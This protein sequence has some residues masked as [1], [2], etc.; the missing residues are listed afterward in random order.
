M[1]EFP[2]GRVQVLSIAW[3]TCARNAS[4][5]IPTSGFRPMIGCTG[6]KPGTELELHACAEC[7]STNLQKNYDLASN[8]YHTTFSEIDVSCEACHG[9]G[10]LHLELATRW[11]F[12]DR[13][14]GYGL[15]Q[16]KGQ[17]RRTRSTF[18]P[19]AIRGR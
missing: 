11:L 16:L 5:C 19:A 6:R 13:R 3:D 7:H 14:Y 17:S 1:V 10:S 2:D 8:T 9:P 18:P 15:A 12:W 4:I